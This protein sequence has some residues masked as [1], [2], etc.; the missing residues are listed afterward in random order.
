MESY[1]TIIVKQSAL[2]RL[3]SGHPW[4]YSNELVR[5][6][7]HL[8]PGQLVEIR[9]SA[10]GYIGRGYFNARSM[11]AV[12]LLTWD[13]L[14]VDEALLE[15]K[16]DEAQALREQWL[17]GD[18]AYRV[19]FS[20]SDGLPGLIVDRY[21]KVLVVQLLTAGIERLMEPI[22][23][24]LVDR[25][26]PDAVIARNDV[27]TRALEGLPREKHVVYGELSSP[28][29]IQKNGLCFEV[30]VW[31]GQKTGFFLDQ[32][33]N[34]RCLEGLVKGAR[35]LDA[36]CYTGAWGL[37][38][39]RYGAERVLG[40]D[41]SGAAIQ[42]ARANSERNGMGAACT[43]VQEDVFDGLRRLYKAGERFDV[44]VLDPPAFAKNRK[45]IKDALRGYNEINRMAMKTLSPGGILV[46]CSCSQL[47]DRETFRKILMQAAADAGRSAFLI[48]WRTQAR[49]HPI[50]L[51]IPE[52]EYLKCVFLR[53]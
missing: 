26:R 20:E 31:E 42:L 47:I 23:K 14:P 52:T 30:D 15:R 33:E 25:F 32:C 19:I 41:V 2:Q 6:P 51:A 9:N 12:R 5:T 13:P 37:H 28:V 35:V 49:D 24:I 8:E 39:L 17:A 46:T 40:F 53:L 22:L 10:G 7:K 1:Y 11:I 18:E 4:I 34:Y 21:G 45:E 48:A 3:K 44:I 27:I 43:F 16:I 50:N 38:A 29:V 36:F